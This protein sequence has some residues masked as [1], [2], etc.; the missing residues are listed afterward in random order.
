[1]TSR[2]LPV[3]W[4]DIIFK[5]IDDHAQADV[6]FSITYLIAVPE[7]NDRDP[8]FKISIKITLKTFKHAVLNFCLAK[9]GIEPMCNSKHTSDDPWKPWSALKKEIESHE[10]QD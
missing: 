1:M 2:N 4:G 6:L 10:G 7:W 3:T 8:I 5:Q 9:A